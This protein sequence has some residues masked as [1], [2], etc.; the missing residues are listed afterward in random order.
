[1]RTPTRGKTRA[2]VLAVVVV[3][4]SG[5]VVAPAARADHKPGPTTRELLEKC[6]E[7]TDSCLFHPAGRPEKFIADR[8]RV[9][10]PLYNCTALRQETRIGWRDSDAETNSIGVSVE[11][12]Y[13]W[14]QVFK[15]SVEVSYGHSWTSTHMETR[16]TPIKVPPGEIG[17]LTRNASMQKVKGTYELRFGKRYHGHYIWYVPFEAVGPTGEDSVLVP[18]TRKMTTEEKAQ[19]CVG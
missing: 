19:H 3:A 1:M 12:E 18:H 16:E 11:A 15:L 6:D 8:K 9:G 14:A 4:L 7:G 13:S 2:A 10:V 17:W 5:T